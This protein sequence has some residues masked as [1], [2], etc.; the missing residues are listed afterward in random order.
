MSIL[1]TP[2]RQPIPSSLM[3]RW[4]LVEKRIDRFDA[5][6]ETKRKTENSVRN[7]WEKLERTG[8]KCMVEGDGIRNDFCG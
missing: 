6:K 4:S 8:S 1:C 7:Y 3:K 2:L 5:K